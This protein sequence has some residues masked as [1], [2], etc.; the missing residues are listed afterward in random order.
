MKMLTQKSGPIVLAFYVCCRAKPEGQQR[1]VIQGI[2]TDSA[3]LLAYG[4]AISIM[5]P[6]ALYMYL[7]QKMN[8][9]ISIEV[10]ALVVTFILISLTSFIACFIPL[11]RI[12]KSQPI[13]ALK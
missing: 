10:S 5:I 2:F 13:N 1:S 3:K 9:D 12:V 6:I 8:Y 4:W 7:T 11:R